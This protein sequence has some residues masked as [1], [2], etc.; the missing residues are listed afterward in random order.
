MRLPFQASIGNSTIVG[1][2]LQNSCS[3]FFAKNVCIGDGLVLFFRLLA[4]PPSGMY[5][6][7]KDTAVNT[8]MSSVECT[9]TDYSVRTPRKNPSTSLFLLFLLTKT[10]C[11]FCLKELKGLRPLK[12]R[13]ATLSNI[14]GCK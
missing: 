2:V 4:I 6:Y 9:L 5:P 10:A 12:L 8:G 7:T 13:Q 14:L 3:L 11:F 1:E